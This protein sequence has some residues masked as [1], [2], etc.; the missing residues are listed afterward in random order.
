VKHLVVP[1]QPVKQVANKEAAERPAKASQG[2]NEPSH[3]ATKALPL[4]IPAVRKPA[5]S[6][7][8][9]KPAS[10]S[11]AAKPASTPRA[12]QSSTLP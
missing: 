6:R 9:A 1:S 8:A 11:A 12:E 3:V 4:P 5:P 7:V 2:S 10:S